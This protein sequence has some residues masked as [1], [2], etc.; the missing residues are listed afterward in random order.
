MRIRHSLAIVAVLLVIGAAPSSASAA[1]SAPLPPRLTL[2][3]QPIAVAPDGAFPAFLAVDDAPAATEIAVDIYRRVEPSETVGVEPK[4]GPEATFPVVALAEA[5][6]GIQRTTAFTIKLFTRGQPNPDPAWGWRIDEPGVYPLRVRLL[7]ADGNRLATMMTSLIR[8]PEPDQQV[9]QAEAS[10]L[11]SVHRPP[12]ADPEARAK[13]DTADQSLIAELDPILA[14]LNARPNLPATFSVTPDTAA[15]I[16]GD[17]A[18]ASD[19]A[20]L[21]TALEPRNRTLLDAPYVGIDPASL[22]QAQL[23]DVLSLERDL[24][25]QTL[26]ELL[27]APVDGTWQ[28]RNRVDGQTL[29]ELR[30]RG[31][32]RALL[33]SDALAGGT[34]VLAPAELPAGQGTVRGV[35]VSDAYALGRRGSRDPVL[36]AHRLLGRLA[37]AGPGPT[38]HARMVV[39]IDPAIASS[40][41]LHIVADAL[42][43]GTAFWKVGTVEG[44]LAASPAPG[45]AILTTPR[46]PVLGTYPLTFR[47]S[48]ASLDSYAGMVGGRIELIRPYDL[49][50]A[51]SAASD[52][53][54]DQRVRDAASVNADLQ[55]PFTSITIPAK[56][57]V[58]LG[59]RDATFPLPVKS[60]LT[61]PVKVVI[62][63][64]SNDR[65][66]FP[67]NRIETT[68]T[69]GRQVVPVRV[70]TRAAGDTPVRITVRS[71]DDGVILAESQY[72]IR[73]TAVSGVG[74]LLTVGAA[75]FLAVWWGRH[76]YRNRGGKHPDAPSASV[77]PD[78]ADAE[79]SPAPAV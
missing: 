37:A 43:F 78:D 8:L 10:L 68:L 14:E 36:D 56:D 22:V 38:G 52:L 2:I 11:V 53:P 17:D 64:E 16:A 18:A 30:T 31:I 76:W 73:S 75:A 25:R 33:P 35:A 46:Q 71:P 20:A 24:G 61:Y 69:E 42:S 29:N 3:D 21:R 70:R 15:R 77:S 7:D 55:T 23:S 63:L 47:R 50:L 74:V 79:P 62:E 54:L 5:Q 34:G 67:H 26:K 51:V 45:G 12:P 49:T 65:V 58:T 44:A 1:P 27:E 13:T 4:G 32:F 6:P 60:S 41:S 72:T 59:A 40:E 57:K 28:V 9:S 39:A 48:S 66:E 19:L